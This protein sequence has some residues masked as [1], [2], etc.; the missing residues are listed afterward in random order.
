MGVVC[1]ISYDGGEDGH[2]DSPGFLGGTVE[3]MRDEGTSDIGSL[4]GEEWEIL[5][6]VSDADLGISAL[7]DLQADATGVRDSSDGMRIIGG[8]LTGFWIE[9]GLGMGIGWGGGGASSGSHNLL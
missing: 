2:F 6:G 3:M 5:P 7:T 1:H 9:A 8:S 4:F